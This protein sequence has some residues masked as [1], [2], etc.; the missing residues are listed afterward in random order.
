MSPMLSFI[1]YLLAIN[2]LAML[3]FWWDKRASVL[4]K[5]RVPERVMLLIVALGGT[6]GAWRAMS[7]YRHKTRKSSF[8]TQMGVIVFAQ[9]IIALY[10][11]FIQLPP[12][13][14]ERFTG[15]LK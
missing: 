15:R 12:D 7:F 4:R 3:V 6:I 8:R 9:I 13:F 2:L 10:L 11:V 5:R 1:T 14:F